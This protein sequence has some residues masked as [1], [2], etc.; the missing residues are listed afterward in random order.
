MDFSASNTV[1]WNSL[2]QFGILGGGILLAN[3]LRRKIPFMRQLLMP[4]AMIAGFVLLL[5]RHT[6]IINIDRSFMEMITYHSIA[7]GFIA[8]TL[9]TPDRKDKVLKKNE[10]LDIIKSGMLV[11]S[12]YLL[13]AIAGT[14]VILIIAYTFHPDM[15]KS[16]GLLL[17]LGFGQ[18]P[19]QATNIGNVYESTFGFA[20]GKSFGI[21][22]ATIGLLWACIGG[23]TYLNIVVRKKNIPH[24]KDQFMHEE[25]HEPVADEGEIPLI[26]AID[27]FTIQVS[28]VLMLYLATYLLSLLLSKILTP[29][30]IGNI[31]VPLIW[32]FNFLFGVVI[33][34]I[35]KAVLRTLR[36]TKLMTRQYTNNYML[37]RIAGLAFDF[38]IASSI[39]IIDFVDMKSLWIPLL[40]LTTVGGILTMFYLNFASKRLYPNY[41]NEGL[42]SMYGML[43]GTVSNGIMLLREIDPRFKTQAANNLVMSQPISIILGFPLLLLIGLAPKSDKMLYIVLIICIIY[44]IIL[45]ILLFR[46][47]KKSS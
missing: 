37:N 44:F 7:I 20:G 14:I 3:T 40:I 9:R 2:I 29:L 39:T 35:F 31:L 13:Q 27:K 41:K 47:K 26:E 19:G 16:A 46:R 24:L 6:G 11:I 1:L 34:L 42:L 18:G 23:V 10:N 45:N 32:G 38:M 30:S 22:V 5:L 43:T 12:T 21:L 28:F 15:F 4:T 8:L 17:P 33:A 25:I 36:K